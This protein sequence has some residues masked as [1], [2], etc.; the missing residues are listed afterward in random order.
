M[1][2][3]IRRRLARIEPALLRQLGRGLEKESLRTTPDGHLSTHPHPAALGSPLTHPLIT[4]DFS[5]S[6]VEL[7]TGVHQGIDPCLDELTRTHQV[8]LQAIGDELLWATSMPCLLPPDNQIPIG[9]YGSSFIGRAK[10]L[11]RTG[12]KYRYGSRMQT[13]SGL[14]YNFSVPTGLWPVLQG[15]PGS[16]L[17]ADPR[18][19]RDQGYFALIRNFRQQS[20]LLMLL[21]GASPLVLRGFAEGL[22][23]ILKSIGSDALGLPHATS[24]RM[25]PLGYQSDAQAQIGASYNCLSSYARSLHDALTRAYPAYEKIGI[26][27]GDDY[28]QLSTSLLQIENEF[29]GTI[30]PK[31]PIKKGERPLTAL[32]SRG[33]EYIEVRLM[34]LDPFSAIGITAPV[35]RFLDTFLLHCLLEDSPR[36]TPAIIAAQSANRHTV[37]QRGREPG[38]HL[39]QADHSYRPLLDWGRDILASCE[40]VAQRLDEAHSEAQGA[41]ADALAMARQRLE[42]MDT[43]PSARLMAAVAANARHS[44]VDTACTLSAA[45]RAQLLAEPLPLD[46][47]QAFETMARHSVAE[48]AKIEAADTGDFETWRQ[49]Y[50]SSIPPLDQ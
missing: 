21:F 9:Q 7:I 38:L 42:D 11:Y 33:V 35:I 29:Y 40:A 45:H 50:I 3:P 16:V 36:D 5:E 17:D 6:Q 41:Y 34:D 4:T 39:L 19:A 49:H 30:R 20:W 47:R 24:L 48:Q 37:A 44:L 25:G 14:H 10:T 46:T 2:E 22:P 26:R 8:V 28:R 18:K 13:I 43:T 15:L 1:S 23:H 12:L 27:Q 32:S 31:Q